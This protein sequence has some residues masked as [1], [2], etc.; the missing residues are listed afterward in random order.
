MRD[1]CEIGIQEQLYLCG[2]HTKY[3]LFIRF[4]LFQS[5]SILPFFLGPLALIL[6]LLRII[7]ILYH[8]PHH[9]MASTRTR[10]PTEK[11]AAKATSSSPASGTRATS[12]R[13]TKAKASRTKASARPSRL[14]KNGR[15]R[16]H[17]GAF[18]CSRGYVIA[19]LR[20]RKRDSPPPKGS[21]RCACED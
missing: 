21:G 20:S 11:A 17:A 7:R 10:K 9:T 6:A 12:G 13:T 2:I 15:E 19:R 3:G 4:L 8:S 1:E 16:Q 18:L 5:H 14:R